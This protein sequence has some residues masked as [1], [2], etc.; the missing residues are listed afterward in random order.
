MTRPITGTYG[1]CPVA[2]ELKFEHYNAR[3][4][5]AIA[6]G[7]LEGALDYDEKLIDVLYTCLG[8]GLCKEVCPLYDWAKVD[9]PLII[10]ALHQD[11]FEKGFKIP[12]SHK[13]SCLDIEKEQN[14]LGHKRAERLVW[15]QGLNMP[16]E[17]ETLL[18]AGCDF[19]Y[20]QPKTIRRL[21][22]MLK[23][24]RI[25]LAVLKN[26]SCCGYP[27]LWTGNVPL[28]RKMATNNVESIENAG[29][30]NVVTL[31][32]GCHVTLKFDYPDLIGK[33]M[34][35]E[36]LHITQVLANLIDENLLRFESIAKKV[37]Y[38][39][40]CQLVRRARIYEEPRKVLKSIPLIE[41]VEP[42]RSAQN[43]W[44]CGGGGLVPL[45]SSRLS[46]K[47]ASSRV[48]ELADT[49]ADT[50]ITACPYCLKML[51]L[52]LRRSETEIEAYYITD[53]LS[54]RRP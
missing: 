33:K 26:E 4:R 6:R 32:P 40:P 52:A 53:F 36:V 21:V 14:P 28:A 25:D 12:E 13:Q 43:T 42:L 5:V 15:T 49:E 30:K 35:F 11:I 18:F 17:G 31:C 39:D 45:M 48:K 50:V 10:R 23:K 37:T 16:T 54:I 8:C 24:A 1:V 20:E 22:N 3:G 44:C 7:I 27:A 29:A 19:S 38:H 2:E 9:T 47:I 34:N 51:K 46:L 41:F